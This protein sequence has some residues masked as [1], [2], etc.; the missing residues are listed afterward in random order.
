MNKA[1]PPKDAQSKYPPIDP[2]KIQ[3]KGIKE[4]KV[5]LKEFKVVRI[6]LE[7]SWMMYVYPQERHD[8]GSNGRFCFSKILE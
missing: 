2:K 1:Y 5:A 8:T 3:P 7:G 4:L 6:R